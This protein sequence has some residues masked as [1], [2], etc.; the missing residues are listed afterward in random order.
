[1]NR[2]PQ[3]Y[4]RRN[5]PTINISKTKTYVYLNAV[6]CS[7]LGPPTSVNVAL[8]VSNNLI[9]LFPDKDGMVKVESVN[10]GISGRISKKALY[11]WLQEH[12]VIKGKYSGHALNEGGLAFEVNIKHDYKREGGRENAELVWFVDEEKRKRAEKQYKLKIEHDGILFSS[13]ATAALNLPCKV[14]ISISEDPKILI[15]KRY[16]I[17]AEDDILLE[18]N[19]YNRRSYVKHSSLKQFFDNYNINRDFYECEWHEENN[20]LICKFS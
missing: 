5:I 18:V 20:E 7:Y 4:I 9:C 8:D 15:V 11:Y 16:P 3:N 10:R 6:A 12:G 17:D 14:S 1:M 13:Q 2:T 19:S